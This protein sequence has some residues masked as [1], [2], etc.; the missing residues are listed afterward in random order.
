MIILVTPEL[1]IIDYQFNHGH[2]RFK[3]SHHG[4]LKKTK[5]IR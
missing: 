4:R 5:G 2:S 3:K 1:N